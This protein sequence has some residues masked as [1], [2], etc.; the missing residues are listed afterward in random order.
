M[1]SKTYLEKSSRTAPEEGSKPRFDLVDG[2]TLENGLEQAIKIG[3]L[4]DNLK[5]SAF[6][7]KELPKDHPL[8]TGKQEHNLNLDAVHPDVLHAALGLF[9]EATEILECVLKAYQGKDF[10]KVNLTEEAGDCEWYLAMLYRWLG[11]LPEDSRSIN[12][13]KLVNRFPDKFTEKYA[14]ERDLKNERKVLEDLF[15]QIENKK[16]N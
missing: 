1:D 15:G 13:T 10:D 5:K 6:Y 3:T 14:Q 11:I 8:K 4:V 12:I 7:G 16:N 9:T 2:A